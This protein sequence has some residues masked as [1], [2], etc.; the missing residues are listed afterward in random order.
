MIAAVSQGII[1][2]AL[3]QGITVQGRQYGGGWWDWLTP[4][5]LL[6]GASVLVGYALL[7]ATWLI[8]RTEGTL[9]VHAARYARWLGASTVGFIIAVSAATPFLSNAYFQRWFAWPSVL[10]AAQVPL[11]VAVATFLFFRSLVYGYERAPF[12]IAL[13]LFLLCFVGLGISMFPYIVP[14]QVTIWQ[15]AAPESS[16]VFMLVGASVLIPI[17][18]AYTGYAYWVFRGKVSTDGYH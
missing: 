13:L 10:I 1:L 12:L 3:L 2:G 4:F 6:T 17:I 15:A 11:M 7:G 16:Q 9:Q 8:M 14:D 18:L 5:S